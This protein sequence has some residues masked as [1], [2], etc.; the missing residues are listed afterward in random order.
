M[1]QTHYLFEQALADAQT[2]IKISQSSEYQIQFPYST[3]TICRPGEMKNEPGR[4][5]FRHTVNQDNRMTVIDFVQKHQLDVNADPE[6]VF[7]PRLKDSLIADFGLEKFH[8][9][10][11]NHRQKWRIIEGIASFI[12]QTLTW[13]PN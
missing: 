1:D 13:A 6:E 3:Y 5:N 10:E 12:N 8:T 2:F 7:L 4:Q 9:A 11:N